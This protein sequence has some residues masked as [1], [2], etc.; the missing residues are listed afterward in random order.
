MSTLKVNDI[1][2]ATSGGGKVFPARAWVNFRGTG[3]VSIYADANVSSLTDNGTGNYTLTWDNSF[4]SA[5]NAYGGMSRHISQGG[6]AP[7]FI[8]L[9][10]STLN[11]IT[12][13][14]YSA[15]DSDPVT[16]IA[17]GNQ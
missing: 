15:Y 5:H 8:G 3:T 12:T 2:E 1:V 7:N 9:T 17:H 6:E 10:A 4:N 14:K 16:I 11:F 13:Y